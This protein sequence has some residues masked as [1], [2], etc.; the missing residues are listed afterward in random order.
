V[1]VTTE[2]LPKSLLALDVEL[3]QAQVEK[4][5][6]RAARRLSQKYNIPGFRKG[7]A[8][9]FI[10][11]NY[12]GR[13]ALVEEASEDLINK[14]FKEALDQEQIAPVGRANLETVHFDEPPFSFRVTVPVDPT[15][16]LADYRAIRVPYEAKDVTDAML[17]DAMASRRERHVVLREPEEPRPAKAG[18]QLTVQLE[19]FLDG[20]PLEERDE[21]T[22]VP[23]TNVVLEPGRLIPGLFEGLIGIEP[24]ETREIVAHMPDD[25]ENEKVRDKDVTFNVKLV[26]LQERLLPEWDELPVLEE[27]EGSLDDLR[28]KTRSELAENIRNNAE[29]ETVDAYLKQLVEQT[30][31]DIPDAMIEQEADQ[32]LHQ[33]G[34]DLE[35]YGITLDQMLQYRGQTHDE[36]VEELK[37][38]AEERLKTT[39]A[40]REIVLAEGLTAGEDE[41]DAEVEQLLSTY[42]EDQRDRA[43][44]LLS[45][46]LRGTVASTVIDKKLRERLFQIAAG[47]A[48]ELAVATPEMADS[49]AAESTPVTADESE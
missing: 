5:L 21:G 4:G 10:V 9:R 36:A 44:D 29:R 46:Q 8:P 31:Y 34:H 19:S 40:L 3:D 35:R 32:L 27:F 39:L 12:F 17:D 15:T 49:S 1:K 45:T 24:G 33:R 38:Q 48:P 20:E 42:E 14:A 16:K 30:E 26:R 41:V 2:K 7:K 6:D 18:D 25:H 13:P 43:R 22:E 47:T 11:E 37:P 28:E 23:E